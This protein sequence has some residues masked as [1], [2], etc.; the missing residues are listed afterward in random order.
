MDNQRKSSEAAHYI[1]HKAALHQSISEKNRHL[2]QL[3]Q[4][5]LLAIAVHML[6]G[7][8]LWWHDTVAVAEAGF[9]VPA[10]A[11]GRPAIPGRP[12]HE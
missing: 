4:P 11:A 6:S 12:A 8:A 2:L 1:Q 7:S 10:I 3:H 9:R 5:L